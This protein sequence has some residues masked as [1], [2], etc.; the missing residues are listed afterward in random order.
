MDSALVRVEPAALA[1]AIILAAAACAIMARAAHGQVTPQLLN[2][3]AYVESRHQSSAV[4]KRGALG[5]MQLMPAIAAWC[6]CDPYQLWQARNCAR[7]L[8]QLHL[9]R[10]G[11]LELALAAYVAGAGAVRSWE[12]SR[13]PLPK[14]VRAYVTRVLQVQARY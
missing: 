4:S 2:A 5:P 13:R 8:L 1:I 7:R 14:R 10:F 11:S 6:R 3:I 9:R 12:A